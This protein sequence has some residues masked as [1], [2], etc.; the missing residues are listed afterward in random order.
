MIDII[1]LHR[2][3]CSPAP[4]PYAGSK[5]D[6]GSDV[7]G[8]VTITSSFASP[9]LPVLEAAPPHPASTL[10]EMAKFSFSYFPPKSP[11]KYFLKEYKKVFV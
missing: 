7:V 2:C 6:S 10:P 11:F 3:M 4:H 1:K 8:I 9:V 5:P